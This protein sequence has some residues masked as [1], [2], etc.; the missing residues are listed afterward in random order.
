MTR[1]F[2]CKQCGAIVESDNLP[3]TMREIYL[4]LE[5]AKLCEVCGGHLVI[6]KGK[7]MTTKP[8]NLEECSHERKTN[9]IDVKPKIE[10]EASKND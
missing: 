6:V 3:P 2:R 9:D 10:S 5:D 7:S 8:E 1:A 4:T